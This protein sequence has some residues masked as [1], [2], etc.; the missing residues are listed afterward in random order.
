[1]KKKIKLKYNKMTYKVKREKQNM[2]QKPGMGNQSFINPLHWLPAQPCSFPR[3]N[4][5][6][7]AVIH[8]DRDG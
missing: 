8:V 5:R 4:L 1:M 7:A 3:R 2:R 6:H